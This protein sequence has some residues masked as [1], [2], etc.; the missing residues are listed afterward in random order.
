MESTKTRVDSGP[1]LSIGTEV[2]RMP[3][4]WVPHPNR[5]HSMP[6][7]IVR[8]VSYDGSRGGGGPQFLTGSVVPR[9]SYLGME[10]PPFQG[11]TG[12]FMTGHDKWYA[13]ASLWPSKTP[14]P[15]PSQRPLLGRLVLTAHRT[16]HPLVPALVGPS[17]WVPTPAYT[18]WKQVPRVIGPKGG[19]YLGLWIL[20]GIVT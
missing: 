18:R 20:Q 7:P 13:M 1:E 12:H 10:H 5:V 17:S 2:I 11:A 6:W 8:V 4:H 14:P 9:T 19:R 16:A 3:P 15:L